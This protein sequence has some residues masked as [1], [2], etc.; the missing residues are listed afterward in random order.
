MDQPPDSSCPPEPKPRPVF[1]DPQTPE[2]EW[3]AKGLDQL[4]KLLVADKA[5]LMLDN[6]RTLDTNAVVDRA[7]RDLGQRIREWDLS[8]FQQRHGGSAPAATATTSAPPDA[9]GTKDKGS[10]TFPAD[11]E[12]RVLI[13]S[14]TSV[15]YHVT[16]E[17][18]KTPKPS[19]PSTLSPMAVAGLLVAAG[20][21]GAVPAAIATWMLKPSSTTTTTIDQGKNFGFDL[22]PPDADSMQVE[23]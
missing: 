16:G 17:S 18:E 6:Q 4:G 15:H 9:T 10:L 8:R 1:D 14:P 12:M 7:Q 3:V 23:K 5:R 19:A 11:D 20:L 13:D 22:L 2:R 21:A